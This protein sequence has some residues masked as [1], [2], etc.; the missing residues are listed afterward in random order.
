VQAGA[1]V[2]LEEIQNASDAF[3]VTLQQLIDSISFE[4]MYFASKWET[5]GQLVLMGSYFPGLVDSIFEH[6]RNPLFQRIHSKITIYQF[7]TLEMCRLFGLLNIT[8]P[9]L[10]L[11]LHSLFQGRPHPYA[12]A[13]RAGLLRGNETD[14]QA[15]VKEF[16]ASELAHDFVDALDLYKLNFGSQFA[17]G[18]RAVLAKKKLKE[19]IMQI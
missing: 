17:V 18:L 3:Q 11:S 19:Q 16:F 12:I 5:A 9:D 8:D 6:R 15:I 7:D 13:H 2:I 4:S 1:V 14:L 10:M